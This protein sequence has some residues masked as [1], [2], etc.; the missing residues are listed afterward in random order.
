MLV[1]LL[2]CLGAACQVRVVE[3]S[4][5]D[6]GPRWKSITYKQLARNFFES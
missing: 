1:I 4:F 6:T 3:G 5:V 2:E